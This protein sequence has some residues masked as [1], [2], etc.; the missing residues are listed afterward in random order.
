[1]SLSL[2]TAQSRVQ[3]V[4]ARGSIINLII[5]TEADVWGD[6][7]LIS[8]PINAFPIRYS[9]FT[10]KV[11]D[12]VG[13]SKDVD[14]L[15]YVPYNILNNMGYETDRFTYVEILGIRYEIFKIHPYSQFDDTFLYYIIGGKK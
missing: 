2:A 11:E 6:V 8:V 13:F 14:V 3:A 10:R 7:Q 15:A 5:P 1:M 4:C 12:S 9:P